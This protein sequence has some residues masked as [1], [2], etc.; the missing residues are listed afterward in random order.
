MSQR[1]G[2]NASEEASSGLRRILPIGR[3][4]LPA[5]LSESEQGRRIGMGTT[6]KK[7][8]WEFKNCGREPG[9][10]RTEELGLCPASFS[11]KCHGINGGDS[12]GR[13]CW[14]IA[15]TFCG[16]RVQGTFAS[17]L[18]KCLDCDFYRLV[19]REEGPEWVTAK[20][21]LERIQNPQ[22]PAPASPCL[23]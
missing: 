16:G 3:E 21:I 12:G 18:H 22:Q 1:A 19:R 13:A 20:T 11:R 23:D 7:N 6:G 2:G 14:A 17:K 8:C 9:G 5:F 4:S 10:S 15:G